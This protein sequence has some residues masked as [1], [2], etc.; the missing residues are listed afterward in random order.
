LKLIF[1]GGMGSF[2][3]IRFGKDNIFWIFFTPKDLHRSGWREYLEWF[4]FEKFVVVV[5][6]IVIVVVF[7][8]MEGETWRNGVSVSDWMRMKEKMVK[9]V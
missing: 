8:L 4:W 7:M 5:C 6:V 3:M 2:E 1:G 9:M